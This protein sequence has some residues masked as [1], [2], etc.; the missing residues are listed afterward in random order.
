MQ[1]V[2]HGKNMDVTAAIRDY[3]DKKI[4]R[5]EKFI[6]QPLSAQVNLAVQRGRHIVE[7]T[8]P[9]NGML[10]RGEEATSDMY[11]SIDLV[12]D[13]LEKQVDRYKKARLGRKRSGQ[14]AM[15][16]HEA[17]PREEGKVVKT[18]Q[19]PTKPLAVD[20][21]VLQM[22]LLGH[23]FFV[24]YNAETMQVNVV[25]RRNDGNY[26]LLEPEH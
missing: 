23:G 25:Y 26:G 17:E 9:L 22:D 7:V 10:V 5:I 8:V 20:E 12:A 2:V 13:K 4:G 6:D 1:L 18:K 11:A 15:L 19:F 21:A 14:A 3:L 16:T 24:F